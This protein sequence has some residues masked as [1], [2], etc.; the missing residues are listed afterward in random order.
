M[1]LAAFNSLVEKLSLCQEY[2]GSQTHGGFLVEVQVT[3]VLWRFANSTYGFQIMNKT[4]GITNGSYNN[5]TN[6]FIKVMR[7]IG[8]S[9]ITWSIYDP[10]RALLNT[11]GFLSKGTTVEPRLP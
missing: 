6:H 3:T 2:I 5:F 11:E 10:Q 7:K 8:E 9:I 4:L 1:T